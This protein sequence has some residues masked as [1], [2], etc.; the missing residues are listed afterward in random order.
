M[1]PLPSIVFDD[2]NQLSSF[3]EGVLRM[4]HSRNSGQTLPTA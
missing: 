2:K 4:I 1:Y 3:G